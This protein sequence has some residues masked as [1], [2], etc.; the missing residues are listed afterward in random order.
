MKTLFENW[1]RFIKEEIAVALS[2]VE[3][4]PTDVPKGP[5]PDS[6]RRKKERE[7]STRQSTRDRA[8]I[9]DAYYE[10]L[11]AHGGLD[12]DEARYKCDAELKESVKETLKELYPSKDQK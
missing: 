8:A 7:D 4:R 11:Q 5:P 1:N 9:D 6:P 10:C 2:E 3:W 12:S